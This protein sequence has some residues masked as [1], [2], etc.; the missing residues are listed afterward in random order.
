[1]DGLS[2]ALEAVSRKTDDLFAV[3]LEGVDVLFCLPPIKVIEQFVKLLH[4]VPTRADQVNVYE[5]IFRYCV[6]DEWLATQDGEIPAGIP[7]TIAKLIIALS[8]MDAHSIEY[9]KELFNQYRK[10][11]SSTINFM[12]RIICAAF[13]G[14]TFESLNKLNYQQIVYNFIQA[15]KKNLE[16]GMEKPYV[17]KDPNNP[18]QSIEEDFKPP[19]QVDPRAEAH[20]ERL[21]R[22]AAERARI[23]EQQQYQQ[24]R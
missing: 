5:Y 23:M 8:G 10:E 9:T 12:K 1:M 2:S 11:V 19:K 6:Q 18:Q 15:E 14:Y 17:F 21:R 4:A 20:M 13:P 24:N 7:E 3:E 22:A 16:S